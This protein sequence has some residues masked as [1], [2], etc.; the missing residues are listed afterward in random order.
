[1]STSTP[2]YEPRYE[3]DESAVIWLSARPRWVVAFDGSS[4]N[5]YG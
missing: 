4:E 2:K 1:M 3:S 5:S